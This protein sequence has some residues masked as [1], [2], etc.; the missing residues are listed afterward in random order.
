MGRRGAVHRLLVVMLAA[1]CYVSLSVSAA[2]SFSCGRREGVV[3]LHTVALK[4][5]EL[6]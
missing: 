1:G 4:G 5:S 3:T 6:G 2:A